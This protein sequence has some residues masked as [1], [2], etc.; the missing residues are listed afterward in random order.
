MRRKPLVLCAALLLL[1]GCRKAVPVVVDPPDSTGDLVQP[2]SGL[3]EAER[4][5]FYHLT[6]GS[7]LMPL[8][9]LKALESHST[10]KP[11]LESAD[12]FGLLPD[13]QSADG[14]PVGLTAAVSRDAR[15]PVKMV[16]INC[17]ACHVG[18]MTY[19]G[20]VV[21]VVGG[22][23]L[24]D[25][26]G[27][28]KELAGSVLAT[29]KSPAKLL[30]FLA[31][32]HANKGKTVPSHAGSFLQKYPS[33]D[34]LERGGE[35]ERNL[36]SHLASLLE[37]EEKQP[38]A[39]LGK[40]IRSAGAKASAVVGEI[41]HGA[42]GKVL[43]G[44]P[45]EGSPLADLEGEAREGAVKEWLE[46]AI[47]TV[48]MMKARVGF[49][50][51]LAQES[52]LGLAATD[53]GPGR[54]DDFG[55]A[56]NLIFEAK[57]A[58]PVSAPCSIPPLWG[59]KKVKWTDWDANT[60]SALGRSVATALAGGAIFDPETFESTIPPRNLAK[61]DELALKLKPPAWP[62][63]VFGKI[64]AEKAKRGAAHFAAHCAK[65]HDP[66]DGTLPD[67]LVDLKEI[68]TDPTR[69]HNYARKLGDRE[70]PTALRDEVTK[71]LRQAYKD[72]NL[73]AAEVKALESL[74]NQWRTTNG[75]VA[76]NLAGAWATAPYLHNGSVPTLHA[77]LLPAKDRPKTF[78]L[79]HRDYD[80]AKV[81]YTTAVD[82]PRF[83]FDTSKVGNSNSGHEFGTNLSE[84]ERAELIEYL[85]TL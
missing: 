4:Q 73:D 34:A 15:F 36:A 75:Y 78:P 37:A 42:L 14:L 13:P 71:Y 74:P 39:A 45:G 40:Q 59:L 66:A 69:L 1:F 79:G 49:A 20:K 38:P 81:G 77:M 55:L 43:A 83:L 25:A 11:F 54:T 44:R 64:D 70:F 9:W 52:K 67:S 33:L 51:K 29:V 30:A 35:L 82:S 28:T 16:G 48:R 17:A 65:C 50:Y 3:S 85:K 58:G 18:E 12:R 68:G 31:R 23:S 24:F 76:R 80:P 46:E 8:A 53:A 62:G 41:R 21:R 84:A 72:E 5:E 61:L 57:L 2:D 60:T 22:S 56:R 27:F 26:G 19:A 32:V 47:S 7:E 6:M 63:E 10:G